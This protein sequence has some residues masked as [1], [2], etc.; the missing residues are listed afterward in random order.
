MDEAW[1]DRA[2][3]MPL[4]AEASSCLYVFCERARRGEICLW[5]MLTPLKRIC[6][7]EMMLEAMP[8]GLAIGSDRA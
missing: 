1:M 7:Y 4:R 8:S 6:R 2:H 3:N 5:V